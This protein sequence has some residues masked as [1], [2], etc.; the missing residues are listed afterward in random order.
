M[1]AEQDPS[2]YKAIEY[3]NKALELKPGGWMPMEGLA[4][5][6][7]KNL[8]EYKTAVEWMTLGI[9]NIPQTEELSFISFFL[10]A[11]IS[12]WK[13]R[14]GENE[15]A[16]ESGRTAY[17]ASKGFY[18]GTRDS[19]DASILNAV[20]H[21]LL[22]L[23]RTGDYAT[24]IKIIHE[25]DARLTWESGQSLWTVF[26]REQYENDYDIEIFDKVGVVLRVTKDED[27]A[28]LMESSIGRAAKLNADTI[29]QERIVK[30]ASDG[31]EWLFFNANEAEKSL[32]LFSE[33]VTLI[34][35][36]TEVVQHAHADYRAL[37]AGRL[38]SMYFMKATAAYG[39]NADFS[40]AVTKMQDLAMHKQGSKRYYRAAY[41]AL[42]YG[43][44]LRE[45]AKADETVWKDPI[46]PSVKQG[47]YLL[48]DDDP[49]NDQ[50]A[51]CQLGEALLLGGDIYNATIALGIT[52]KPLHDARLATSAGNPAKTTSVSGSSDA[53]I[54]PSARDIQNEIENNEKGTAEPDAAASTTVEAPRVIEHEQEGL[55]AI[56]TSPSAVAPNVGD[57]HNVP[58]NQGS[59]EED[60]SS[61]DSSDDS[62][63]DDEGDKNEGINAKYA[64]FNIFW[65]CD[66]ICSGGSS[67]YNELHFCRVCY[68]TCFCEVCILLVRDGTMPHHSCAAD[69][70]HVKAF[71]LTEDAV[72]ITDA[73]IERRFEMQQVWLDKLKQEWGA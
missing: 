10:E 57:I 45:Y 3:F 55:P 53:E 35:Q 2:T 51:Y 65:I 36:S 7:G 73:L 50:A 21:Y 67:S 38:S 34:D 41:S 33:I 54:V 60:D 42:V 30:V 23:F 5:C 70:E 44:W 72:K 31:A 43:L 8:K 58:Q 59:D 29:Q 40:T 4:R 22:A 47:L 56:A 9:Q 20:S 11:R 52:L 39:T 14:L 49:W 26:L 12:D 18:Y 15:G 48:S 24:L 69:H 71:P 13:L 64:G 25:L 28:K 66:G 62:S 16:V 46:K 1:E 17:E 19:G 32:K 37:A 61:G 68:D 63:D 6:Y 27:L